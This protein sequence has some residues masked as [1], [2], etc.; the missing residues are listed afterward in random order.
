MS[1]NH[2]INLE[3][4]DVLFVNG[5]LFVF[6]GEEF[7]KIL[8]T[9]RHSNYKVKTWKQIKGIVDGLNINDV[10]RITLDVDDQYLDETSINIDIE[11]NKEDN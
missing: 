10:K 5:E 8:P 7:Q 2:Y 3:K 1:K 6:D 4:D 11:L 9:E